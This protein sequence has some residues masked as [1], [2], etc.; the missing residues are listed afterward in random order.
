MQC[1]CGCSLE[2]GVKFALC[3]H[4]ALNVFFSVM[5]IANLIF[6]DSSYGY[7][8]SLGQEAVIT[9]FAFAGLPLIAIAFWG[10]FWRNEAY[11]RIYWY[12]MLLYFVMDMFFVFKDWVA[13]GVCTSM[14]DIFTVYG[15]AAACGITRLADSGAIIVTASFQLYLI[16]IVF[17]YCYYLAIEGHAE[18]ADLAWDWRKFRIQLPGFQVRLPDLHNLDLS[19]V[20][21][22][23]AEI[24]PESCNAVVGTCFGDCFRIY[25][26]SSSIY[27]GSVID[28]EYGTIGNAHEI[29]GLGGSKPFFGRTFHEL[30][31]PPKPEIVQSV[32]S[33]VQ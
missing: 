19:V 4:L 30:S 15:T 32:S 28:S 2:L 13:S 7:S 27:V 12:Y 33:N 31:Y 17:S 3:F 16:F 8:P 9:M 22:G 25:D 23:L 6:R 1:C 26:A 24:G 5:G 10:V 11:I 14:P 18:L 20:T 21:C 29:K